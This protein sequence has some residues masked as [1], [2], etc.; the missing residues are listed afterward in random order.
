LSDE[1]ELTF[2]SLVAC[3]QQFWADQGCA[4]WQPYHTEV[5]AGTMNPAT[6]LRV[7]GPEPW[8][9]GYVEPSIRPD[10]GRYG[11]N[12]NRMQ[13]HYQYQVILKPDPGNPQEIY[14]ESLKSLGIDPHRH[15]IRF[16]EDNWESPALGAWGLGWEVWLD[17]QEITQFTYFQQ[18]GGI[19]LDPPSVEITYGLERILMTLQGVDHFADIRWDSQLSYG[20]LNT[21]GERE[22]SR[23]YFE[24]ADVERLWQM[25]EEYEAE[26]G[27]C[28]DQGL[29]LPAHDYVLKCSH[30]FNVLDT[31]GAIGVTERAG[32]FGRMR[33][34]ARRVAEAY[35]RHRA[36]MGYPGLSAQRDG[37][38]PEPLVESEL[39]Q[40]GS[41]ADL[42]LEIGTEEL[43]AGDLESAIEQLA[44]RLPEL[45][46]QLRLAHERVAIQGT[47]RRLVVHVVGLAA[48]QQDR[49]TVVK[50][51][52]ANR[53]FD[54]EGNP[55]RA[56][57][58]F[59]KSRGVPVDELKVEGVDD[60][61]YVTAKVTEPG[62]P[63]AQVLSPAIP[64]LIGE[65]GF[66]KSMRWNST[67]FAF[68]RPIRW[69]MA[70]HGDQLI[71][72]ECA[73]LRSG[74]KTRSLRFQHPETQTIASPA[75]YFAAMQGQ[76]IILDVGSRER[77]I[78]EQIGALAASVG[79]EIPKDPELLREVTNLVERP[80]ALLGEFDEEFLA[81]PPQVLMAVMKKHQR[82]FPIQA[83]G[84]LLPH[85]IAVRNGNDEHI[86]IVR[87]GNEQVIRARFKDAAYF[88]QQ[89]LKR[90]LAAYVPDLATLTFQTELGSMLDK[91][92]RVQRL[93][94]R[95]AL[96]LDLTADER[97]VALAAARLCKADLVT[98]MV[99]EMTSL[100]GEMG[101][102]YA[103]ESGEPPEVA[104]AIYEHYL[105]EHSGDDLPES[106]PGVA[107]AVADRV[108]TLMGLFAVGLQPTGAK[109]PF[110]LRR[111]AIGL[112]QI[113]V[114]AGGHFD[115]RAA[116]E[117]AGEGLPVTVRAEV[118]EACLEFI[119][120][121]QRALLRAEGHQH[122]AVDAVLAVQKHDPAS[123]N[124]AVKELEAWIARPDWPRILQAYSRCARITRDAGEL[125][126]PDPDRMVEEETRDLYR[127]LQSAR[128]AEIGAGAV[129]DFLD[130][131]EPIIPAITVFFDEVLVMSED[132]DLRRNRLAL[133]GQ[134]VSLADGIVDLSHLEGF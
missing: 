2:Q 129:A 51:P 131:F 4:I 9:V 98:E 85:F 63:A 37:P 71:P 76:G 119:A 105:P 18:A 113:L 94:S 108:D 16:V 109:D 38:G 126:A 62:L 121:R 99:V 39:G 74:R 14:L 27:S 93:V 5:G 84:E 100:Q 48:R 91:V 92:Q 36:E 60:G 127:A 34:L 10:D 15:D 101:R 118:I 42:V 106:A 77:E 104:Q 103:L 53:A 30:T 61:E 3:L 25:F 58:G 111:A 17:G 130:A 49:V 28:L 55:T 50:G 78:R 24:V 20:D 23:Y 52:P 75:D 44:S 134:I 54:D 46:R 7:L 22:F 13:L 35:L 68:S 21:L 64:E 11:E 132:E 114:A 1:A 87:R 89:D 110:A 66:E 90:P 32:L 124:Q 41:A 122:D 6:V 86:D 115:L 80:H 8:R 56:A 33:D 116:L 123:A 97:E 29:I 95:L 82:Y 57:M 31:R 107:V 128:Q 81:L 40:P 73:G 72:F 133:L 96:G 19:P 125:G 88:I 45:L 69:L 67:D 12:P 47:P 117:A 79:G 120:A 112:V 102:Y 65:L 70:L 43:P 83:E 26:A 59:A